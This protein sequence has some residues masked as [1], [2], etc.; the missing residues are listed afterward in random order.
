M[1]A[2]TSAMHSSGRMIPVEGLP[3]N[4]RASNGIDNVVI[5]CTPVFDMPMT[6]AQKPATAHWKGVWIIG[7][8]SCMCEKNIGEVKK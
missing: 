4:S 2:I 1:T 8:W 6:K 7:D 5:P 3:P